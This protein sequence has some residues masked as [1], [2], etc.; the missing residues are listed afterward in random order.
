M[1]GAPDLTVIV[2]AYNEERRIGPT[3][4]AL[5]DFLRARGETYEV[6]VVDDG[7]RDATASLVAEFANAHPAFA[8]VRLPANRGKGAAVREGLAR[9]R[10]RRVLFTDAD[11][12]TPLDELDAMDRALADG[13]DVIIASR[14]LRESRL[15]IR[16]AWYREQMGKAFNRFVRLL[17]GIPFRDTQCGFK[18]LRGEDARALAA[19]MREDGFSFDVELIL[20]ARR[21]GLTLRDLPVRW[22]NDAGSR[23]SA[24]RDSSAM[25]VSLGRILRRTGRY[26]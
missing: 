17:T 25:L 22:R 18:L 2:P 6:L 14:A 12:S 7:S 15:E 8:L 3:L 10:G 20:L 4:V 11:L 9:S 16:Q 1:E 5:E 24:L 21:R 19:E 26:R 13:A 23:V